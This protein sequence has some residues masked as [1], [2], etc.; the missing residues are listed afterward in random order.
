MKIKK[1]AKMLTDKTIK[2]KETQSSQ[3]TFMANNAFQ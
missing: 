3:P 2:G 1:K